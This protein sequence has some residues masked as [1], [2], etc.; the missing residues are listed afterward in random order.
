MTNVECYEGDY[1][2]Y[3]HVLVSVFAPELITLPARLQ[4]APSSHTPKLFSRLYAVTIP[5][6][7]TQLMLTISFTGYVHH[8]A[9]Q[10]MAHVPVHATQMQPHNVSSSATPWIPNLFAAE[11]VPFIAQLLMSTVIDGVT[12][13]SCW[14][15][16]TLP[17]L[18][19]QRHA[20]MVTC[21]IPPSSQKPQLPPCV[22]AVW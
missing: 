20:S 17:G 1:C 16:S 4:L 11:V 3:T 14:W 21:P 22:E 19:A 18:P 2:H 5:T 8:S 6:L 12:S 13:I 15:Q 9:Y 10:I 7:M